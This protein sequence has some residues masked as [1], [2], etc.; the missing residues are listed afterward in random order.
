MGV[1]HFSI[2]L[3]FNCIYCVWRGKVLHLVLQSFELTMQD[4]RPSLFS[5]KI[6]Y[7]LYIS[8]PFWCLQR[9]LTAL[10]NL[11]WNTWKS[12]CTNFFRYQSKIFLTLKMFWCLNA[13]PCCFFLRTFEVKVSNFYWHITWNI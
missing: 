4:S 5:I 12:T 3:M 13:L 1:C 11:V 6:F 7:H 2:A 9:M 10:F 8:D